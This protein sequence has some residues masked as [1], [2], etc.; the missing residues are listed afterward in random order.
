MP[1]AEI[2]Q[3]L[4]DWLTAQ[5]VPFRE[6]HH[7][8]TATSEES[9]KARGEELRVGGKALVMRADDSF[10][11]FVLPADRKA[12]SGAIRRELQVGKLRFASREELLELT[13]LVPGS[14]PPFGPPIL[15]FP[16]YVDSA[17]QE[18]DRIAFNAGS[19]TDSMIVAMTDYLRVAQPER[20]FTFSLLMSS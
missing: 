2:L 20:V 11:L 14:V 10:A 17:I 1:C 13:G 7:A 15:P 19:L 3:S 8:P 6:V 16:L 12:D 4:R 18:N 9:A 5:N